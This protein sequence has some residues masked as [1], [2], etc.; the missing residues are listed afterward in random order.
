MAQEAVLDE[1][2]S[3]LV[4]A[5]AGLESLVAREA[6]A[7]AQALASSVEGGSQPY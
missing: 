2:L 5:K 3:D 6:A 4:M 7:E 1:V